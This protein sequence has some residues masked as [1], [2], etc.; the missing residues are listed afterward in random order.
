MSSVSYATEMAIDLGEDIHVISEVEPRCETDVSFSIGGAKWELYDES[1]VME[2]SGECD[3]KD[4]Y[5]DC[6]VSP[7]KTGSYRLKLRYIIMDEIWVD[8]IR[9]RVG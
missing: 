3:I 4:H 6:K 5:L 2:A 1:G 8:N 7:K 9:L